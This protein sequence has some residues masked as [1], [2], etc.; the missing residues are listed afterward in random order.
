[1][2]AL[3][4]S[5]SRISPTVVATLAALA[6]AAAWD[7]SGL[8][9]PLARLA[10]GPTGFALRDHWL[11]AGWLH[12]GG[13]RLAWL[14][15]AGLLAGAWFPWGP[16]R[17]LQKWQRL[18]LAGATLIA[19]LVVSVLKGLSP[20]NCPWDLEAFGG[21]ARYVGHWGLRGDAGAGG[22]CFPAGHASAGFSFASG[23]FSFRE[24]DPV[25][26]RRW[27]AAALIAGL[28]FALAQQWRG[29]HF[30]SHSLWT[31]WTCWVT[32]WA[33]HRFWP[34]RGAAC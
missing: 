24:I 7:A 34:R 17:R 8:D 23:F 29:A 12:D 4:H 22:H 14:L 25:L 10:G 6:V 32:A 18:R 26:A 13:R 1:M 31:A 27:L 2:L 28:A 3:P 20:A 11:L 30:M 19:A 16:L 21:T 5:K 15:V 9:L 33:A